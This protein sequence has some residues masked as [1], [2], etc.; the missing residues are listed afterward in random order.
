[1]RGVSMGSWKKSRSKK[2]PE[3]IPLPT[4]KVTPEN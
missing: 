1:M 3:K 2:N 4:E